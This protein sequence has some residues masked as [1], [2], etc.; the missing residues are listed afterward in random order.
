MPDRR[1]HT[2]L[3]QPEFERL[4]KTH[5]A[6]LCNFARQYVHDED[7]AQDITQKVFIRL[8]EKRAEMDPQQSIKSY[9]FT[10]VRNRC[11]NYLR[12]NKKYRSQVLDLDCGEIDFSREDEDHLAAEDL[13]RRI[14]QALSTLP[15]KCRLVFEMSRYRQMKYQEI[16]DELNIAPKTVEAHMSKALKTLRAA[17]Q[18]YMIA[19]LFWWGMLWALFFS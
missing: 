18:D 19:L 10:A 7:A 13:R 5:F 16:A 6:H 9:L 1:E 14:E 3:D 2:A 17:L 15:E 12:D 11:L 4:F 8:W